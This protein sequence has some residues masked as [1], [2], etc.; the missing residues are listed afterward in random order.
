LGTLSEDYQRLGE[1][2]AAL[3]GRPAVRGLYLPTPVADETF[4][5]EFGFVFLSDGSVGPFYVSMGDILRRLWR[6]HPQPGDV[7]ANPLTLLQGFASADLA[8][9]ALALGVYNALSAALFRAAG[10]TPRERASG[11]GLGGVPAGALVGMV[12]FFAPLVDRLTAQGCRVLILELSPQRIPDADG[13]SRCMQ[14]G[15]LGR[16]DLVLC[17]ASTLV[18]D[19]LE[20]LLAAIGPH[21]Q[22][23]LV[24]PS[25]SGLP[26]P[27]FARGVSTVGGSLFDD[28]E[29]LLQRLRRG[30]S[31]GG[32]ARKYQLDAAGYP[33]IDRLA[34][35]LANRRAHP[36][37]P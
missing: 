15:Q 5:D 37:Q 18:N 11:S 26:D 14:A 24:G 6:R 27:L 31:W 32:A 17:T 9:R 10:F 28:P 29:Q 8:D 25:G 2:L 4:R 12:G 7:R 34:K 35:R 23:E 3:L 30:E 36:D 33:G 1:R 19:S 13:V 21:P 16:C 20:G 22:V